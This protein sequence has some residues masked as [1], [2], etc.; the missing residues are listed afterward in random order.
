M[1]RKEELHSFGVTESKF[2]AAIFLCNVE[3]QLNGMIA[4]HVDD[5]LWAGT[6][7]FENYVIEK[8]LSSLV[9]SVLKISFMLVSLWFKR[10][11]DDATNSFEQKQLRTLIG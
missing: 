2:D 10:K 5:V 11:Q 8:L 1:K 4:A 3:E 7:Q 6:P 9:S